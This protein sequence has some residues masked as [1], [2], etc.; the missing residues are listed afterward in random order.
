MAGSKRLAERWEKAV[1]QLS[2]KLSTEK[3]IPMIIILL[4]VVILGIFAKEI[5]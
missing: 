4:A 5:F 2:V 3:V 1:Y